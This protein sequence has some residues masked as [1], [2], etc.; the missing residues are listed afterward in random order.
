MITG[1][2][3]FN[4]WRA[5]TDNDRNIVRKWRD[6]G[7]H[8]LDTKIYDARITDRD[9][10]HTTICTEFSLGGYIVKPVIRAGATWTVYGSGDIVL[11]TEAKVREGVPF[12]PRFGLKLCMPEGN[13]RVEYFG[14]GPHESYVDKR[15]STWKSRFETTVSSMHEN[16]LRPQENGSH[17]K[18]EWAAVTDL[19]GAGLLFA[20]MDDFSFNASHYT[21]E[22][23]TAANH[24]YELE[25]RNETIIHIDYKVSGVGSNSCGPELLPKYRLDEQNISFKLRMK[26]VFIEDIDLLDLVNKRI[27][28]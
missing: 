7:Y 6:E 28:E 2:P 12:L 15:R 3:V 26:P 21:P 8:R 18:T 1:K 24:P 19:N 4:V 10:K 16:Y 13:E 9:D 5:P 23:I 11:E 27:S 25:K 22:D 17:F 20:G 14:Y